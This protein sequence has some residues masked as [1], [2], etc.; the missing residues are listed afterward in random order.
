MTHYVF[1]AAISDTGTKTK[2]GVHV[3]IPSLGGFEPEKDRFA[4]NL[5]RL[6][7]EGRVWRNGRDVEFWTPSAYGKVEGSVP[8][9]ESIDEALGLAAQW[10]Q[11]RRVRRGAVYDPLTQT[12]EDGRLLGFFSKDLFPTLQLTFRESSRRLKIEVS[13]DGRR[14]TF[15]HAGGL[16][17]PELG[18]F[19]RGAEGWARVW[20][21]A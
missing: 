2:D 7:A 17:R 6:M 21:G 1:A 16:N 11:K 14:A 9:L 13:E 5:I 15:R 4:G 19:E 8:L 20:G 3:V 10:E 18:R 12:I